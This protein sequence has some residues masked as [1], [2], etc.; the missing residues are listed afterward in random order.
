MLTLFRRLLR[1]YEERIEQFFNALP[2]EDRNSQAA[3]LS[4]VAVRRGEVWN[5]LRARIDLNPLPRQKSLP[6][7]DLDYV[8]AETINLAA[9]GLTSRELVAQLQAGQVLL[10]GR[11][12]LH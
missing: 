8:R 3:R 9:C 7:A 5:L 12:Y 1:Q 10:D 2:V 4:Y 11:V 6:R